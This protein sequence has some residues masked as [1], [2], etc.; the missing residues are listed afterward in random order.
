MPAFLLFL[1]NVLGVP[2]EYEKFSLP[3]PGQV[4][5]DGEGLPPL[6]DM[7]EMPKMP[8]MH[9]GDFEGGMVW[10]FSEEEAAKL[11]WPK[12]I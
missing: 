10:G 6:P 7:K 4:G 11:D 12:N 5:Q 2:A 9:I 3:E 8:D 1:D